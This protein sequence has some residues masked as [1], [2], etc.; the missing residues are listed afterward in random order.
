MPT[1][2]NDQQVKTAIKNLSD[3]I[4][5]EFIEDNSL[6]LYV[7]KETL[8]SIDN[9]KNQAIYG[10]RGI[11]KTHLLFAFREKLI[12]SFKE[13]RRFPVYI[14]LRKI[15]PLISNNDSLE[16]ASLVF[17]FIAQS[18][19]DQVMEN[20]NF[21][22][23]LNEWDGDNKMKSSKLKKIEEILSKFNYEFDGHEYKKISDFSLSQE[24]M[25]KISGSLAI[26]KTPE[27]NLSKEYE[28]RESQDFQ[29]TRFI[30]FS[31]ITKILDE[32]PFE[33]GLRRIVIL[34][35]EWAE[36]PGESQPYLAELLKRSFI[37][38]KYSLKI[39]AIPI[40]SRLGFK[41]DS[42]FIGLEE[43]GDVFGYSLDNR[44]VFEINKQQTRDFFNELLFQHLSHI[45][46][47]IFDDTAGNK[48]NN[49]I[50]NQFFAN[51]ALRE[52]LIA[53]AGIPRDFI[54]LF[55]NSY[56][57]FIINTSSSNKRIGVKHVRE[58]TVDWYKTDKKD[59]VDNHLYPKQLL[60]KIVNEIV[61]K[62]RKHIF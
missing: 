35:D 51:I 1:D 6:D 30:S 16:F 3:N 42:K 60:Q 32:I 23:D 54:S 5:A 29:K 27:A 39:A 47:D 14:D 15:L 62:K 40:R 33:F 20:I 7:G 48:S 28:Q 44:F 58:A 50:I 24:E 61:L 18:I 41:T 53:S 43:G 36:I 25:R 26:N 12:Q 13:E 22:F 55:I 45:D 37:A 56:D 31:D 17:K 4:R 8:A 59:Q 9:I 57:Q 2:I 11:G 49:G 38:G 52:I 46:K 34:L 21:I 10:R 19:I